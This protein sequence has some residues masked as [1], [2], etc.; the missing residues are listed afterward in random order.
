M[1]VNEQG[2]TNKEAAYFTLTE[3]LDIVTLGQRL[4][5]CS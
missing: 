1:Q 5:P 4:T 3:L 2:E